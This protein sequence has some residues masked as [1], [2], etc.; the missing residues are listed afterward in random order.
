MSIARFL[1]MCKNKMEE[2]NRAYRLI[3]KHVSWAP[4]L[5]AMRHPRP[6]VEIQIVV[7]SDGLG[8]PLISM[9]AWT[10]CSSISWSRSVG[11]VLLQLKKIRNHLW[12][13]SWPIEAYLVFQALYRLWTLPGHHA[14]LT[15]TPERPW[16]TSLRLLGVDFL[17]RNPSKFLPFRILTSLMS[18]PWSFVEPNEMCPRD[19]M[20]ISPFPES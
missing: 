8:F 15:N 13:S 9:S 5:F 6:Q 12:S 1:S 11:I 19:P 2:R 18:C 10:C 4:L 3:E 7:S 14:I 17:P 20:I 16:L